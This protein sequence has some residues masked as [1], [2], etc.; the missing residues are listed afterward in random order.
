M[1]DIYDQII[2]GDTSGSTDSV[3]P[4]LQALIDQYSQPREGDNP[5]N[6]YGS[7]G[8]M[9]SVI[10]VNDALNKINPSGTFSSVLGTGSAAAALQGQMDQMKFQEKSLKTFLEDLAP[11][12]NLG[13]AALPQ[14]QGLATREGQANYLEND[15]L[16]NFLQEMA[17][18]STDNP[19]VGRTAGTREALED[20]LLGIG[21]SLIDQQLNRSMSLARTGQ[22]AAAQVGSGG[23]DIASGFGNIAAA[24]GVGQ[25]NASAQGA[26]NVTGI[27]SMIAGFSD[28]RLKEDVKMIGK[29]GALNIYTWTWNDEASGLGLSGKGI[30]HMADEVERVFPELVTEKDGYKQVGYNVIGKTLMV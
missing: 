18:K 10:D 20:R 22:D 16:T 13:M 29:Y 9:D 30:G 8:G 24:G 12:R 25:A 11:Y 4:T 21:D 27:I 7:Y 19:A 17:F 15:P 5:R 14:A 1:A 3:S 2:S 6:Q 23:S 26:G 28:P